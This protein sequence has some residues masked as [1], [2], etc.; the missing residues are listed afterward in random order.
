MFVIVVV[1][2]LSMSAPRKQAAEKVQRFGL[3]PRPYE[4]VH[5]LHPLIARVR[6]R[7]LMLALLSL[8]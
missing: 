1:D 5:Y 4:I 3:K 7:L 6:P 2:I 8:K